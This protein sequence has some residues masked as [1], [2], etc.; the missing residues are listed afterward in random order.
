MPAK[1]KEAY[2]LVWD[3]STPDIEIERQMIRMGGSTIIEGQTHGEGLFFHYKRFQQLVWPDDDHHRWSDLILS[4]ILRNTFTC[5][6][7]PKDSGK[8]KVALARYGLTDYLCFPD[9]TMILIS[10]TDLRGL[11]LRVWGELKDMLYKA[12][13]NWPDCPGNVVDYLHAICTDN[14]KEDEVRDIRKGIIA[15]PCLSSSGKYLGIGKYVGAK[16]KRRRLLGDELQF[17]D[18]SY[19]DVPANMNSGDFKGVFVGNPLGAGDPLDKAA[20]PKGGWNSLPEPTKTT[21]WE[22]NWPN[23]R[24][25]NLI[26]TD[27]PNFDFP[28]DQ[29][30]KFWYLIGR[31]EIADVEAF[32]RK[33]SL[34]YYSQ[35]LGIRKTGILEHRVLPKEICEQFKAFEPVVWKGGNLTKVYGIDPAYGGDRCVAGIIQFGEDINGKQVISVEYTTVIPIVPDPMRNAEDQI[36]VF[37]KHDCERNGVNPEN[38]FYDSTGRGTLGTSFA[39]AWSAYTNTIEFG[40]SPT[41]RPVCLDLYIYDEDLKQRRLKRC[42]EHYSKF[43]TELAFSVRYLVESEQLKNLPPEV[44]DECGMR[45]WGYVRGNKI[46]VEPK[47]ETKKRMNRSP[48]LAD[49][50]AVAVEGARRLGFQISKMESPKNATSTTN[51]F[52]REQVRVRQEKLRESYSLTYAA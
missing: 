25:I 17:M 3:G 10:S 12:K 19:L 13:E 20:E 6:I 37:V 5:I 43:V 30:K 15:I 22:N 32:Y 7:G 2:G 24:T 8:T 35:A 48:D 38:V 23:G 39:R 31:K 14:I 16:Q 11:E 26:G 52:W 4:E 44:A 1:T 33:N 41:T 40:G 9:E 18:P 45:E 29:P 34:Q 21:V 49:F 36:A 50:L 46:E 28:A 27:S 47:S 51:D 42:D